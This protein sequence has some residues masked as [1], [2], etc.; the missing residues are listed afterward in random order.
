MPIG[1]AYSKISPR[2][3]D[4]F[5]LS[6]GQPISMDDCLNFTVKEF[7]EFLYEKMIKEEK[8]AL[9]NVSR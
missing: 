7:N 6:L 9:N 4:K 3:R 2:F 5:C 8:I 1:I